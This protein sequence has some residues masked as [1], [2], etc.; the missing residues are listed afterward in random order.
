MTIILS[1]II[2]SFFLESICSNFVSINNSL[3]LPLFSIISLII[4]YP[5]FN[6]DDFK[7]FQFCAGVGLAYDLIFTNTLIFNMV[8]FLGIGVIIKLINFFISNNPLNIILISLLTIISYR[9]ITFSILCIVGY[10]TF[11]IN[12]LSKSIYSSLLL[13]IIYAFLVYLITDYFSH[14]YKIQKID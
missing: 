6:N 8:I 10:K 11:S 1:V 7:F 9:I 12:S 5:Y 3:F 2:S 13:N 14:K 4:I